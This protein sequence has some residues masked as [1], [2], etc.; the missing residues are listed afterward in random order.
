MDASTK[1]E[2]HR[3]RLQAGKGRSMSQK[4]VLLQAGVSRQRRENKA[5]KPVGC[6][7]N[8]ARFSQLL[9]GPRRYGETLRWLQSVANE[10]G[11]RAVKTKYDSTSGKY[12][13]R[14]AGSDVN[15][16]CSVHMDE[17]QNA[18]CDVHE[19]ALLMTMFGGM[20]GPLARIMS[21]ED[22]C[23]LRD[24]RETCGS[25]EKSKACSW[26]FR[27]VWLDFIQ[28]RNLRLDHLDPP[29]SHRANGGI[30]SP[31]GMRDASES[32]LWSV[33]PFRWIVV[34]AAACAVIVAAYVRVRNR[35][36]A[37]GTGLAGTGVSGV[38][39]R[40]QI[41]QSLPVAS[42]RCNR[43]SSTSS[44]QGATVVSPRRYEDT[45]DDTS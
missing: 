10:C 28:K 8:P 4:L 14:C 26:V 20:D 34:V 9:L 36:V 43:R 27:D 32:R 21:W 23:D 11:M 12:I 16:L 3:R 7:P 33:H 29:S 38:L 41:P 25:G 13:S 44:S 45:Y 22:E 2:R 17:A 35:P 30:E 6:M 37:S 31:A 19:D 18:V 1:L 24:T 15:S 39:R 5:I 40:M 42:P